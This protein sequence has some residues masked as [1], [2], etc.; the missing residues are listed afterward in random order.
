MDK[1]K[2]SQV[3]VLIILAFLLLITHF[4][5]SS[6]RPPFLYFIFNL[7]II[8]LGAEAGLLSSSASSTPL[9]ENTS[10]SLVAQ[11]LVI[12]PHEAISEVKKA[13]T[14]EPTEKKV[15]HV[16]V[17]KPSLFFIAREETEEEE[18]QEEESE[19]VVNEQEDLCAKAEAF[20]GN[21]YTQ[22]K[23]QREES[24]KKIHY[25]QTS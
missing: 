5:P 2:K 8:S 15:I 1:F 14:P 11:Q 17:T 20:I 22:L 23:I 21:F 12:M 9:H 18:E 4:L 13:S 16:T 3:L 25:Q 6:M 7:L 19:G 24:W 10:P